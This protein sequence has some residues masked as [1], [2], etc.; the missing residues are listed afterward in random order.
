MLDEHNLR[1]YDEK[2]LSD[3]VHADEDK[4]I[5][6]L[7]EK[8]GRDESEARE[9]YEKYR[10]CVEEQCAGLESTVSVFA[11]AIRDICTVIAGSVEDCGRVFE[12]DMVERPELAQLVVEKIIR[13]YLSAD[14][15]LELV[16]DCEDVKTAVTK[17]ALVVKCGDVPAIQISHDGTRI[18]FQLGGEFSLHEQ[19]S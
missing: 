15:R 17:K 14:Y 18:M 5:A 6:I 4:F 1:I 10:A 3:L 7:V 13:Y 12:K 2:L 9:I 8:L 16:L 11:D 19:A